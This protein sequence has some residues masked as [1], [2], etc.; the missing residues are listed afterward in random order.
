MNFIKSDLNIKYTLC[1]SVN[2][3]LIDYD[4]TYSNIKMSITKN[5]DNSY[6]VVFNSFFSLTATCILLQK[7]KI[8]FFYNDTQ[9]ANFKI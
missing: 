6:N 9:I 5:K 3:E 8:L 1:Q 2:N 7:D 4:L